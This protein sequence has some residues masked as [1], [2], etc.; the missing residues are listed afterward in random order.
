MNEFKNALKQGLQAA[1]AA[2]TSNTEVKAVFEELRSEILAETGGRIDIRLDPLLGSSIARF[3]EFG[4]KITQSATV[5]SP[6]SMKQIVAINPLSDGD[7]VILAFFNQPYSGYP[8]TLEYED[9]RI[10]CH[11]QTSLRGELAVMLSSAFIAS[12]LNT[13]LAY[14]SRNNSI[15][16][17]EDDIASTSTDSSTPPQTPPAP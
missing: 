8:C 2:D 14:E 4:K 12:K 16:N 7:K 13:V 15:G 17:A 1:A 5:K 9:R 3:L 11:D 6:N 10:H